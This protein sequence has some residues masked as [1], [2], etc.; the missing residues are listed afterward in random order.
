MLGD[1][2]HEDDSVGEYDA[3][4]LGEDEHINGIITLLLYLAS[5]SENPVVPY[6][7]RFP[8]RQVC[9]C[10]SDVLSNKNLTSCGCHFAVH[11]SSSLC[12]NE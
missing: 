3:G 4:V 5:E 9:N 10:H 12:H 7:S 8:S 1:D 11:N 6:K 2:E